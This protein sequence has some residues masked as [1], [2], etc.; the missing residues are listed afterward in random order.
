[1]RAK[2]VLQQPTPH[3]RSWEA[4]YWWY[5]G[6]IW[7]RS[8]WLQW[9]KYDWDKTV[10]PCKRNFT[11]AASAG[12][13]CQLSCG[14]WNYG[15]RN[16]DKVWGI[17]HYPK[18]ICKCTMQVQLHQKMNDVLLL[19][20]KAAQQSENKKRDGKAMLDCVAPST[21]QSGVEC[22]WFSLLWSNKKCHS[23]KKV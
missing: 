4:Q 6:L 22:T 3:T 11:T 12:K 16:N 10:S 14:T 5:A 1:M 15:E 19:H 20:N 13:L 17:C 18:R 8:G 7:D 9:T 23:W 21:I 2:F